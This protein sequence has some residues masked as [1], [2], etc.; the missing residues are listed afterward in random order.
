MKNDLF[1]NE[2]IKPF[3]HNTFAYKIHNLDDLQNHHCPLMMIEDEE[4]KKNNINIIIS[5]ELI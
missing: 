1:A 3:Y 4:G 5:V 2:Q